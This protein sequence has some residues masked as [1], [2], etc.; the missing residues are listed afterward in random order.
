MT[1]TTETEAVRIRVLDVRNAACRYFGLTT[2]AMVSPRRHKA[3][4]HPRQMAMAVAYALTGASLPQIG[5]TFGNRDH[6]TVIHAVN[7]VNLRCRKCPEIN[8]DFEAVCELARKFANRE[9]MVDA[10]TVRV[11][12]VDE[13]D[14][15]IVFKRPVEEARPAA[16]ETLVPP[17]TAPARSLGSIECGFPW[18][19]WVENDRAFR[20]AMTTYRNELARERGTRVAA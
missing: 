16:V 12:N 15:G 11:A 19:W 20:E 13:E 1:D 17:S 8:A 6:T 9:T 10:E 14:R 7:A 5:R 18:S 2:Q 4:T 3:W